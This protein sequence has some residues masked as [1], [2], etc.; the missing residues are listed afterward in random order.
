[1]C[2][3]VGV[4]STC[5]WQAVARCL[6]VRTE[7]TW[8]VSTSY[9]YVHNRTP[10]WTQHRHTPQPHNT[11][12]NTTQAH[13]AL[14]HTTQHNTTHAHTRIRTSVPMYNSYS[15]FLALA[16]ATL[17]SP[18]VTMQ[19]S[20]RRR[21]LARLWKSSRLFHWCYKTTRRLMR[22][23]LNVVTD[24]WLGCVVLCCV[25]LCFWE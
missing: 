13:T 17:D 15:L 10:H 25:V 16:I 3:C 14:W 21:K 7:A 23:S 6:S 24:Q 8:G 5:E 22:W 1:M 11:T 20:L 19:T 12:Q 18:N 9:A 4:L 2:V